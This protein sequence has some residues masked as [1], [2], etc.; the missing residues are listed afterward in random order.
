MWK[1]T[2][3]RKHAAL[4]TVGN[5]E[6]LNFMMCTDAPLKSLAFIS[7]HTL[8]FFLPGSCRV[9]MI[10]SHRWVL[11]VG[12]QCVHSDTV[13]ARQSEGLNQGLAENRHIIL[14]MCFSK[15]FFYEH[16]MN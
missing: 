9:A 7:G 1:R 16:R 6:S 8:C 12:H 14:K 2:S 13:S 4:N 3:A 15:K 11:K 10:L 5:C